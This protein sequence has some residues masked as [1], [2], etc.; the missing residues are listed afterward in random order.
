MNADGLFHLANSVR[1]NL[2][3]TSPFSITEM[4]TENHADM[5]RKT[6]PK[7]GIAEEEAEGET[8]APQ[9]RPGNPGPDRPGVRVARFDVLRGRL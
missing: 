3:T 7:Q 8:P 1:Q 9:V 4:R 2:Q 6:A 5:V